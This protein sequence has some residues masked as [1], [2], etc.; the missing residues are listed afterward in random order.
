MTRLL[1]AGRH[2]LSTCTS[3]S[4]IMNATS[5]LTRR[6]LLH[7]AGA[8]TAIGCAAPAYAWAEANSEPSGAMIP[9]EIDSFP[10]V[11]NGRT[12]SAI[13]VNK[14]V[15]GPLIRLRQGQQAVIQVNDR[16]S[17]A[18]SIHWHGVIGRIAGNAVPSSFSRTPRTLTRAGS[19]SRY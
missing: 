15:P 12:G 8:L 10:L 18:T 17:E 11:V 5:L 4:E 6:Q 14:S 16:L 19:G 1:R 7:G 3:D 2:W 9:L 13:A